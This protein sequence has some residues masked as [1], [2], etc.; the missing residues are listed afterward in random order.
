MRLS[1]WFFCVAF[2]LLVWYWGFKFG[3]LIAPCVFGSP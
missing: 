3:Q 2:V 1:I